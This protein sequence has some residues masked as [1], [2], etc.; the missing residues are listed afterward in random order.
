MA[1]FLMPD[2]DTLHARIA[3]AFGIYLISLLVVLHQAAKLILSSQARPREIQC[4]WMQEMTARKLAY[5]HFL[6][7][8][9]ILL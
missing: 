9:M 5:G 6:F 3:L 2:T 4:I 7:W 1:A 8:C